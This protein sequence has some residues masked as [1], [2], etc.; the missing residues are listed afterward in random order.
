MPSREPHSGPSHRQPKVHSRRQKSHSKIVGY[1]GREWWVRPSLSYPLGATVTPTGVQFAVYSQHAHAVFVA[2]FEMGMDEPVVLIPLRERTHHVWHGEV[3]GLQAGQAY[4]LMVDGPWDPDRGHRFNPYKYLLDPYAKALQGSFSTESHL[5]LG[6]DPDHPEKD[7]APDRRSNA[8]VIPKC[9]VVGPQNFDW[10]GIRSPRHSWTQLFIYEAHVKGLTAH[11]TSQVRNP[12]TYLGFIE[13]IPYLKSLGITAV[14]FLPLQAKYSEDHLT[15][16]GRVNYWGYNTAAFFCLE[17]G[18]ASG[19]HPLAALNE[20]KTLVRECHRADIEVILDVVYNHTA[21]GNE[22]GPTLSLKGLDNAAYYAPMGEGDLRRQYRN[23]TGCGNTLDFGSQ[24]VLRLALDSLRYL[25]TECHVDGFRFDLATVL[26]RQGMGPYSEHASFFQAIAQD[27]ILSQVKLIAEPW[28]LDAYAVGHFP[29]EWSEW[30]GKFRDSVRRFLKGNPGQ[31]Q[32]LAWRFSGSV[33]LYSEVG[34]SAEASIQFITCHDGFTLWDWVSYN[35]KHNQAN[36]ENNRDGSDHN[37]SWNCGVE[38]E[39]DDVAIL[40]L[41]TQ[42]ARNAMTLLL[43]SQGIP[44]LNAG[45]EFLRTQSGN[46][47]P[48]CQDNEL[49]WVDWTRHLDWAPGQAMFAFTRRIFQ[50]RLALSQALQSVQTPNEMGH[51]VNP[52]MRC[53]GASGEMETWT[54]Q[55][56]K[57]VACYIEAPETG[58]RPFH[59]LG[60]FFNSEDRGI[61]FA[62]PQGIQPSEWFLLVQTAAKDETS[63][64]TWEN[65]LPL[66]KITHL[67]VPARSIVV[68]VEKSMG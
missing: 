24:P 10:Q 26:G 15:A 52:V 67:P 25:A 5:H 57:H 61:S 54:S 68:V 27:P 42:Q 36:G 45:D 28:D 47:N 65:P 40:A 7:R 44:M 22:F 64:L 18:Y 31:I 38:G 51:W 1:D 17:P 2:L 37:D 63:C 3:E 20:F 8:R 4:A 30:N 53:T 9:I 21:E 16:H 43:L 41:R 59:R 58:T 34:R 39:T 56:A 48:Y 12:G 62:L 11:A 55:N 35:G 32:E 33:D 49:G 23:V 66:G 14:E 13:K 19:T 6:Y 46:N 50:L 60:F 29:V